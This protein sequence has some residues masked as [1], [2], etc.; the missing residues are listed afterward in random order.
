MKILFFCRQLNHIS[1]VA[2]YG[3]VIDVQ[4]Y[5]LCSL[6]LVFELCK[7]SLENHIFQNREKVPWE[8]KSAAVLT[9]QWGIDILDA[10]DYI[11]GKKIVHRDLKLANVLVSHF[12]YYTVQN[13]PL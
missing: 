11:H 8:T 13:S 4:N 12:N 2:F 6:A 9:C 5:Q 7:A 3:V 10:L 1:I